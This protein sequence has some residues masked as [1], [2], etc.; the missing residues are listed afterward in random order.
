MGYAVA[1][2]RLWQAENFRRAARGRLAEIFGAGY[3]TDDILVRT[4]GYTAAA[5]DDDD[6]EEED[7]KKSSSSTCFIGSLLR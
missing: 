1:T 7:D 2:D 3:L 6:D 5:I 4:T